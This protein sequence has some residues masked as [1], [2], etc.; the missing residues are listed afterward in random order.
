MQLCAFCVLTLCHKINVTRW[1]NA[2]L[3]CTFLYF[4]IFCFFGNLQ[5][6]GSYCVCIWLFG[7]GM[8][9]KRLQKLEQVSRSN[10][11]ILKTR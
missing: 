11:W 10:Q 8:G 2:V 7:N 4:I 1:Y 3:C 6:H 5:V 9:E